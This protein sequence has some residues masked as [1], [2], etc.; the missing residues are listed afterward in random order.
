MEKVDKQ[1]GAGFL[2][3]ITVILGLSF[4]ISKQP[5]KDGAEPEAINFQG[6]G[7][8]GSGSWSLPR[9]LIR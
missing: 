3:A 9:G 1:V 8:C 2:V 4:T 7:D 6:T 5:A